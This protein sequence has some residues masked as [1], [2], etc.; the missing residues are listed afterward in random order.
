M[1]NRKEEVEKK[2]QEYYELTGGDQQ[3]LIDAVESLIRVCIFCFLQ[4]PISE[5]VGR[6]LNQKIFPWQPI[7]FLIISINILIFF[8][9]FLLTDQ[10]NIYSYFF[11]IYFYS[12]DTYLNILIFMVTSYLTLPIMM[13]ME[14]HL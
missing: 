3:F 13:K 5:F 10:E 12:A 14:Q 11:L 4:I 1:N 8:L 9:L 7:D 2:G 6:L